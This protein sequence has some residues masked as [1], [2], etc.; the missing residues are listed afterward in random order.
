[1][2]NRQPN[3]TQWLPR[4]LS[5]LASFAGHG[6][7]LLFLL[8]RV[9][10][11]PLTPS[12]VGQGMP[13][14]SGSLSIVY[15]AP[16]GQE[17]RNPAP[18]LTPAKPKL[19]LDHNVRPEPGTSRAQPV[20]AADVPQQTARGGSPFGHVPGL[21]LTGDEVVP[22]LPQVFPDPPISRSDLPSGV[23]GDV[24]VEVTIDEQG[25]VADTRLLQ[26]IG[27][28]IEQKVIAVLLRWHFR[29]ATRNG[30]TIAS[31]HIVHFH[32]PS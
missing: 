15:L 20:S 7:L 22:A 26:G 5:R 9:V 4:Y 30:V 23:E 1:M 19:L 27:Y 17:T 2:L 32:Y 3:A 14:S 31:Q 10:P 16:V 25:N 18:E 29:P 12:D 6:L 21:P 8:H 24:I 13:R 28:G 11:I